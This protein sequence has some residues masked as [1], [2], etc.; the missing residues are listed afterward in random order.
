MMQPM[1]I[2][3]NQMYPVNFPVMYGVNQGF[4]VRA[5]A[6]SQP[7]PLDARGAAERG[8]P[9][10]LRELHDAESPERLRHAVAADAAGAWRAEP[11][12]PAAAAGAGDADADGDAADARRA[13]AAGLRRDDGRRAQRDALAGGERAW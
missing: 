6:L 5:V 1:I 12:E 9:G 10:P 11:A 7:V 3:N 2:Q 8:L 13:A 4:N